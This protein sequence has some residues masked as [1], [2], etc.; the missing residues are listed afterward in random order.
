MLNTDKYCQCCGKAKHAGTQY[1]LESGR[2]LEI[3]IHCEMLSPLEASRA[4]RET[5]EREHALRDNIRTK[6]REGRL[7]AYRQRYAVD[8]K[9]C[10]TC[11]AHKPVTSYDN[12][13]PRSDG[14]QASCRDCNKLRMVL[15]KQPNGRALWD[16][17]KAE[18]RKQAKKP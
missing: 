15:L 13:A 6:Q 16:A 9:Q 18:M 5:V 8:G 4:T 2:R 17:T 12:C 10:S 14:L 11:Q 7:E 3:C 1:S